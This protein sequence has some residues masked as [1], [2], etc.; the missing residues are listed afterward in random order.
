MAKIDKKGF[1]H[2]KVGP[3]VYRVSRGQQIISRKPARVRQTHATKES[4]LEFGLASSSACAIRYAF[5]SICFMGDQGMINRLNAAVMRC[6]KGNKG[7]MRGERDLHD[8]DLSQLQGFQFNTNSPLDKVLPVRPECILDQERRIQVHVPAFRTDIGFKQD[9]ETTKCTMRLMLMV[10]NFKEE[11]FECL[12][13]ADLPVNQSSTPKSFDWAPEKQIPEG[14]IALVSLTLQN[15]AY[16]SAEQKHIY[17]NS[18]DFNPAEIIG[19]FSIEAGDAQPM[20]DEQKVGKRIRGYM[21]AKIFV[22]FSQLSKGGKRSAKS[23]RRKAP[24]QEEDPLAVPKG[25]IKF[26]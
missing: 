8:G 5:S 4:A 6:I 2:G 22:K 21:G 24:D 23:K 13:H 9:R 20:T 14:C 17:L 10:M 25:K 15:F 1:L 26:K 16:S 18:R 19:A 12:E 3:I 7:K 11:Y